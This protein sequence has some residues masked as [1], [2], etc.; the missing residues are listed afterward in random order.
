MAFKKKCNTQ[1]NVGMFYLENRMLAKCHAGFDNKVI[2]RS[3]CKWNVTWFFKFIISLWNSFETLNY[4]D[5]REEKPFKY[6]IKQQ[7]QQQL[8]MKNVHN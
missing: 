2:S 7:Q 3:C 6:H 4:S 5:T 1:N 8:Q